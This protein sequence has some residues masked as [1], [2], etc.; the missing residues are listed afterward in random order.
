MCLTQL[1]T[2][3]PTATQSYFQLCLHSSS[4]CHGVTARVVGLGAPRYRWALVHAAVASSPLKNVKAQTTNEKRPVHVIVTTLDCA[5]LANAIA[6]G[7]R[8]RLRIGSGVGIRRK[9]GR[10][11]Q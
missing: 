9:R 1:E 5:G 3:S 2:Y 6:R 11:N 8:F 7:L 10:R 4:I